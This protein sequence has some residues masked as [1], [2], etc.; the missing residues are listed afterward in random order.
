MVDWRFY[1][2]VSVVKPRFFNPKPNFVAVA[3]DGG[4]RAPCSGDAFEMDQ[5]NP[6]N[7]TNGHKNSNE[8][9]SEGNGDSA[10]LTTHQF[11]KE[12]VQFAIFLGVTLFPTYVFF[13]SMTE[14]L[15]AFVVQYV[16]TV[17]QGRG[18]DPE[19]ILDKDFARSTVITILFLVFSIIFFARRALRRKAPV[20]LVSQ[21]DIAIVDDS[22]IEE[23][24]VQIKKLQDRLRKDMEILRTIHKQLYDDNAPR[25]DFKSEKARYFVTADGSL[26]VHKDIVVKANEKEGFVW[27]FHVTG[28]QESQPLDT[29]E[30]LHF[31]VIAS[32]KNTD[33]LHL[34]L[35]DDELRKEF[36]IYF[37]PI[38]KPGETRSFTLYYEWP[39][40]FLKLFQEGTASYTWTNRASSATVVG[41][42][43]AEWWFDEALGD[44]DC[45]NT[46]DRPQ[47]LEMKR[48]DPVLPTR[49]VL[50][51]E[52]VPLSNVVYELTFFEDVNR[53]SK[54]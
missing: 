7:E 29:L 22:I 25:L 15:Q 8:P 42:F 43:Y 49:W 54:L 9:P 46:G 35:R 14:E 33:L 31:R 53:R 12:F 24:N 19:Y 47:N 2:A 11:Y 5:F 51:G 44:V 6:K 30:D 3:R 16:N 13:D 20:S 40:S 18:V 21:H 41:D 37:L 39:G 52:T 1:P 36:V 50:S 48:L 38:L 23:K 28:D 10:P 32:D 17:D 34:P 27:K 4:P 26:K 45:R